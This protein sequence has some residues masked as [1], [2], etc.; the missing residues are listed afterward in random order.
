MVTTT[1]YN[2]TPIVVYYPFPTLYVML[3]HVSLIKL[4]NLRY[5]GKKEKELKAADKGERI[6]YLTNFSCLVKG[7]ERCG[8][9]R[10]IFWVP[11]RRGGVEG[12]YFNVSQ[13]SAFQEMSGSIA[14]EYIYYF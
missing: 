10:R 1:K 2:Y 3:E 8:G 6:K 5:G 12:K 7:T 13:T 14:P 9:S 11:S 4:S